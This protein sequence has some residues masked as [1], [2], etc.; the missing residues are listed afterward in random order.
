MKSKPCYTVAGSVSEFYPHDLRN[1]VLFSNE[2]GYLAEE[3]PKQCP[4][5]AS[6]SKRE[7][8]RN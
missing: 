3:V 5:L 7:V 6:S 8:E 1:L 2:L 4:V